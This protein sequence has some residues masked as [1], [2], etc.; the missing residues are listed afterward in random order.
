MDSSTITVSATPN[1]RP[2]L[3]PIATQRL[4]EGQTLEVPLNATDP[5]GDTITLSGVSLPAFATLQD[6]GDGTGKLILAP[7]RPQRPLPL[8]H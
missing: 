2:T 7:Q 4:D 8:C 3:D 6:H 1:Q 5:D